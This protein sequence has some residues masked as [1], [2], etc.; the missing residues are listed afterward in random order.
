[1]ASM[2]A[3]SAA[4]DEALFEELRALSPAEAGPLAPDAI[5]GYELGPEI[6]RGGQGIV[7]RAL[8]RSTRRPVALKVLASDGGSYRDRLRFE[9]EV[10]LACRLRHPGIVTVHDRGVAGRRPWYAME[11]VGGCT[12]DEH[13]A[14]ARPVLRAR[15][16]L[17]H[18]ICEAVAHAHRHGVIH[19]DLK[20]RNVL[21]DE[22]G[23][24]RVLD[25]GVARALDERGEAEVTRAGEFAGT[26]T[27]ASPE[28][29][30]GD[31]GAVD[32]RTDVYSLG[33]VLYEMV[34]GRLPYDASG[35][36]AEVVGRI[37][38]AR[39]A[40]AG[41]DGD[42]RTIL[43]T[44]LAKDPEER[45]ASVE[46]L[47]RDVAHRLAGEPIEARG[48]SAWYAL[49]K[50][51][52]RHRTGVALAAAA[53]IAAAAG[54]LVLARAHWRAE[55]QRANAE[56]VR[57]IFQ[58]LLAAAAPN[59]MGGDVRLLE[60]FEEAAQRI[61]EG[62][63]D[64]PDAQAAV[65]LT[66]GDTY[67][68]LLMFAE[69]VPHLRRAVERTRA[70]AGAS[71]LELAQ[72]LDALGL[73]L[74]GVNDPEAVAIQME[75][76]ALR[77]RAL[78]GDDPRLA[79]SER[80]LAVALLAQWRAGEA[81][82]D[83]AQGLLASA[84]ERFRA[85]YGDDHP[86]SAETKVRL[87]AL[88][89]GQP[90]AEELL[91]AAL[92]AFETRAPRDPRILECL[93]AL[94]SLLADA[95][96]FD[97]AE[98]VLA[99]SVAL[100]GELYGD[101]RAVEMLRR[102]ANL[103]YARGD[104]TAAEV[105]SRR[106]LSRALE[107]WAERLAPRDPVRAAELSALARRVVE[108]PD[109]EPPPYAEAFAALRVH[110]GDGAFELAS[111]SNGIARVLVARGRAGET[112]PMLREALNVRCRAFGADCPIRRATI[113]QLGALLAGAGRCAEAV[114]LLE[115]SLATSLRLGEAD[116]ELARRAAEL[117]D[118]CRG[119]AR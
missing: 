114:P 109:G 98:A 1:M 25:F 73:A 6:H 20:P 49:R 90:G 56:L 11:L 59:R 22:A 18:A 45:Y 86:D 94:S 51:L 37:A 2:S 47:A 41:V 24:P 35:T 15:L 10:D 66:I 84:L 87:A 60:M 72:A 92:A 110:E 74:A 26:L 54:A 39:P 118:G 4:D 34:T 31:P 71:G 33:V 88:R 62:L 117:L 68:R 81:E 14:R 17:F 67:R 61:E 32:T 104:F 21:V 53:L 93:E 108:A 28:Q 82:S 79:Q 80:G 23:A 48:A 75:A 29:V 83:R 38:R 97:E 44:A 116:G 40:E 107:R 42:L 76:L 78:A 111:W 3:P 95:G 103:Q 105:L 50:G 65:Q 46:A 30:E 112:E 113:E 115:E 64:A 9:R 16:E 13:L 85:A 36:T 12:L 119:E 70:V 102:Q 27:Y 99:R 77:R 101:E 69:A 7:Y 52:A 5:P 106:A 96:R 91:R 100:T 55:R 63:I 89:R 57:E 8:Q 43:S 19:R 58:D